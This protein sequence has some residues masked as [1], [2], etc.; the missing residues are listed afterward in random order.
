MKE[1]EHHMKELAHH[2]KELAHHMK[3]LAH[4]MKELA[5]HMK[6]PAGRG[7]S[8]SSTMKTQHLQVEGSVGN[9]ECG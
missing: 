3:E 9:R 2:K 6:E 5:H 7:S 1:P 4:H 8:S